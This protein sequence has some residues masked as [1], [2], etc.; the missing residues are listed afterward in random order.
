MARSRAGWLP[1]IGVAT[2][3]GLGGCVDMFTDVPPPDASRWRGVTTAGVVE[4]PECRPFALDVGLH[5][6]PLFVFQVIG[7]RANPTTPAETDV[8]K[9]TDSLGSWWL[10][11][12]MTPA[13]FVEFESRLLEPVMLGARPYSVW[14][15]TRQ[16]DHMVLVESGSP[17]GREVVLTRG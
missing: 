8:G 16:D 10:E 17:C 1:L 15:G 14:R 13:D 12:Y 6:D 9:F 4:L 2:T 7:G 3:L 11:G 5:A